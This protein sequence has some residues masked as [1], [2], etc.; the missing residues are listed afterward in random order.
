MSGTLFT[1]NLHKNE[2][3]IIE[4]LAWN[5]AMISDRNDK[6]LITCFSNS[7]LTNPFRIFVH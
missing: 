1:G 2:K 4:H 6:Y 3:K 7:F 5:D